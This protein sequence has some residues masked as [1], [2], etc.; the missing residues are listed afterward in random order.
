MP[1]QLALLIFAGLY[2]NA[3]GGVPYLDQKGRTEKSVFMYVNFRNFFIS[4]CMTKD[5]WL[6]NIKFEGTERKL[7]VTKTK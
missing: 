1:I 3:G 5:P 4:R 6:L 2:P 7:C